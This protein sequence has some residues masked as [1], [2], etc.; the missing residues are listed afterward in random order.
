MCSW[1]KEPDSSFLVFTQLPYPCFL[2]LLCSCS[3]YAKWL[4]GQQSFCNLQKSPLCA[5]Y[6]EMYTQTQAFVLNSVWLI[7]CWLSPPGYFKGT[8]GCTQLIQDRSHSSSPKLIP[9][10]PCFSTLDSGTIISQVLRASQSLTSLCSNQFSELEDSISWKKL[11]C[12]RD[13]CEARIP[14]S[15]T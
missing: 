10:S 12:S 5:D 14:S 1:I 15:A 11:R 6:L 9:S 7:S 4:Y 3:Q 13:D 2:Q 8:S